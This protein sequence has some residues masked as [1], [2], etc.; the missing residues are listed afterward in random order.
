MKSM[1]V[2]L[3]LGHVVVR[4]LM[5]VRQPLQAIIPE[6]LQSD[7]FHVQFNDIHPP[8]IIDGRASIAGM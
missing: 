3:L 8:M 7:S 2:I 1:N 6:S 4:D 5:I